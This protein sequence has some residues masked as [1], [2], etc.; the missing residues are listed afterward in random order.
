MLLRASLFAFLFAIVIS[1]VGCNQD[2]YVPNDGRTRPKDG[3]NSTLPG[4]TLPGTTLP[5]TTLPG[6]TLPGTTLPGT[7]LPGTTLP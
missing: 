4:T 7:T 1:A 6:T 5:G 3:A 2:R